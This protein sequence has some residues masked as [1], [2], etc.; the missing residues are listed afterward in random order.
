MKKTGRTKKSPE[1]SALHGVYNGQVLR[2]YVLNR[3]GDFET[4]DA[5]GKPLGT[6]STEGDALN[7][8]STQG[9]TERA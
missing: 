7:A 5:T 2:G 6:F 8:I 3:G 9:S 1:P 4:W